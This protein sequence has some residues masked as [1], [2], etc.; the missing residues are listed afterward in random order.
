MTRNRSIIALFFIA[1]VATAILVT[2]ATAVQQ[3]PTERMLVQRIA[4]LEAENKHRKAEIKESRRQERLLLNSVVGAYVSAGQAKILVGQ[5][6]GEL[7]CI[8]Q[9]PVVTEGG[10]RVA[11]PA[12]LIDYRL[13][14]I[15]NKCRSWVSMGR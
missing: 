2:N 9:L 7:E 13:A 4:K 3:S 1:M 5:I 11:D 15:D 6:H 14:V 8:K 12:D 10:W